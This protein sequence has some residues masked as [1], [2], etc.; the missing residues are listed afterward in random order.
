MP[1]LPNMGARQR[2][3]GTTLIEILIAVSFLAF[4]AAVILDTVVTANIQA[5]FALRRA[6]VLALL[7]DKIETCRG[8]ATTTPL[9]I[10]AINGNITPTG[11]VGQV[12]ISQ[13]ITRPAT[14]RTLYN[15]VVTA[16]W[17]E[18]TSLGTRTDTASLTSVVKA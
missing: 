18:E 7:Q 10:G 11:F 8:T 14:T 6:T 9:T 17:T 2:R 16:T 13:T 4:C 12:T 15:V 3:A 1:I 5:G